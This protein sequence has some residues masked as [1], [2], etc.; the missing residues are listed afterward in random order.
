MPFSHTK[1]VVDTDFFLPPFNQE[2]IRIKQKDNR[3]YNDDHSCIDQYQMQV[4]L[5]KRRVPDQ[6]IHDIVHHDGQNCRQDIGD[7]GLPIVL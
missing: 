2:T 6:P 1:D 3:K 5:A 4:L 7:V